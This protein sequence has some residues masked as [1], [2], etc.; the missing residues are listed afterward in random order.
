VGFLLAVALGARAASAA[1]TN[2]TVKCAEL[3]GEDSA[4]VEARVR[5]NLLSAGLEPEAV[6]LSCE[7]ETAQTQVTGNGQQVMA[8]SDRAASPVKEALL[9]SADGAL[10]AW[11]AQATGA[12]PSQPLPEPVPTRAADPAPAPA[13]AAAPTT[14]L[15]PPPSRVPDSRPAPDSSTKRAS[16]WLSAGPRSELW[17]DGS[18]LGAQLGLLRNLSS[19]FLALHAAYLVSLPT[20]TRFSAYELQFGAQ[21][22][23]QPAGLLGLRGALGLGLSVFS[24]TP[25]EGVSVQSG[26]TNS[27]LPCL[28]VELSRPIEFGA[29][30]LLPAAGLRAFTRT[31]SVLIDGQQVLALPALALEASLSL[32]LKV[33]G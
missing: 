11:S 7:A 28:S 30:A 17:S 2:V 19:T 29:L 1:E 8:R 10:A 23:W 27:T 32:A 33:G 14:P 5:A 22:G 12:Q 31:R 26:S 21:A 20:S 9:A 16:T 24:A 15:T 3:S 25:S 4:Q 13:L 18:G 6:E